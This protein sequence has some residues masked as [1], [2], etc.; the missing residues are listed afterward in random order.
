MVCY[1]GLCRLVVL[2]VGVADWGGGM[3]EGGISMCVCSVSLMILGICLYLVRN[4]SVI[5]M[6]NVSWFCI[7]GSVVMPYM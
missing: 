1:G 4:F 6:F 2:V 5:T 7:C 3:L